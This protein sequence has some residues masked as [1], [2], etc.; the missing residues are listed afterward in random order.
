MLRQTALDSSPV[1]SL[2]DQDVRFF[3][4]YVTGSARRTATA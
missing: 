1:P 2:E 3:F 4:F